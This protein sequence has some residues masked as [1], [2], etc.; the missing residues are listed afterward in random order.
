M[1]DIYSLASD[2][3]SNTLLE[4]GIG[5]TGQYISILLYFHKKLLEQ[6]IKDAKKWIEEQKTTWAKNTEFPG[7]M[8]I[9]ERA[10]KIIKEIDR[11]I[12]GFPTIKESV[13][14]L[15]EENVFEKILEIINK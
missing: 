12:A 9:I 4:I 3:L 1:P 15:E 8:F 13:K 2:E 5:K 6:R 11:N 10:E 14:K 7:M